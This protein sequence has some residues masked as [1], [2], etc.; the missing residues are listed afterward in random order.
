[1]LRRNNG[2]EFR[3]GKT[4]RHDTASFCDVMKFKRPKNILVLKKPIRKSKDMSNP[5]IKPEIHRYGFNF[6]SGYRIV[7]RLG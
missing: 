1:M 7:R 4:T 6:W 5:I 2:K 3:L